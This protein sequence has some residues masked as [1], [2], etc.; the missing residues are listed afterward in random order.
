MVEWVEKNRW[1]DFKN[2]WLVG[3]MEK[4]MYRKKQDGWI[5]R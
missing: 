3:W 4:E 2:G 5:D 1:I